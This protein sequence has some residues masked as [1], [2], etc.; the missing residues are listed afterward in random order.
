MGILIQSTQDYVILNREGVNVI[1]LGDDHSKKFK[2][3]GKTDLVIH[4]LNSSDHL[5]ISRHNF[6]EFDFTEP[7]GFI[8]VHHKHVVKSS[9]S[10]S[11]RYA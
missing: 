5:K 10:G 4:S 9:G 3:S 7:V 11:S 6:I 1:V 8:L 2:G